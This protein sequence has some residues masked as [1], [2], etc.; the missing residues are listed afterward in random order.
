[1]DNARVQQLVPGHSLSE[2]L[3][4]AQEPG[5][6]AGITPGDSGGEGGGTAGRI[7]RP[8]DAPVTAQTRPAGRP[9]HAHAGALPPPVA[10]GAPSSVGR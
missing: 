10:V 1:M 6:G 4:V 2:S 9:A 5:R 8:G 7:P 3:T